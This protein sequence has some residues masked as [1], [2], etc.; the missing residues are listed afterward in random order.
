MVRKGD[1]PLMRE[2]RPRSA[3]PPEGR[4]GEEP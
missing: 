2:S 3:E 4:S 1:P